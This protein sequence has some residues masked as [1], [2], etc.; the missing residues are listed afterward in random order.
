MGGPDVY[1]FIKKSEQSEGTELRINT[2]HKY[3]MS[4]EFTRT[5]AIVSTIAYSCLG[6]RMVFNVLLS[7]IGREAF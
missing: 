7:L 6:F 4:N 5:P 1:K 3:T 2:D